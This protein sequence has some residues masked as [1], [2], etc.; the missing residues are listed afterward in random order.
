MLKERVK[1]AVIIIL[2]ANCLFLTSQIWFSQKLWPHGYDFFVSSNFLQKE[3]SIAKENIA[4]PRKLVVY[5]GSLWVPYYNTNPAFSPLKDRV[6][7]LLK[8]FLDG[9]ASQKKEITYE[10]WLNSLNS[11]SVY[12][13]YPITLTGEVLS[14]SMGLLPSKNSKIMIKDFIIMP[15]TSSNNVRLLVRTPDNREIYEY[16]LS[17]NQKF[18]QD[19]LVTYAKG[20][21]GYYEF[22]FNTLLSEAES[23]IRLSPLLLFTD[24]PE[25]V[26]KI[27]SVPV[28]SEEKISSLLKNF[29]FTPN[30]MRKYTDE[31]N[32]V[33]YVENYATVKLGNDG[34]FEYRA[35]SEKDAL[36]LSKTD[37]PYDIL[38]GV[39]DFSEKVWKSVSDSP[40]DV[41]LT[42]DIPKEGD[43][44]EFT[45]D[46]YI[47]GNSV[48]VKI[49]DLSHAIEVSVKGGKIVKY[50]HYLRK[51]LVS[52]EK[53][54]PV[55]FVSA[56][57]DIADLFSQTSDR[58][59]ISDMYLSYFDDG[60]KDLI[61]ANWTA[62]SQKG[63]VIVN[64]EEADYELE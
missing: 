16:T 60:K 12:V 30:P 51:Y 45:F 27:T 44:M 4:T 32:Y 11:P 14:Y 37:T 26:P 53:S 41:L 48:A 5:D 23:A 2:I 47:S 17:N 38:C 50:R 10:K 62:V 63:N 42:S 9:H 34:Y 39:I 25:S 3:Y 18:P 13:E 31:N 56:L 58:A 28:I 52:K 6:N 24:T 33:N 15:S 19:D 64:S 59:E 22:A 20:A 57:D 54:M 55:P 35:S 8:S 29:S 43:S 7:S 21:N 49:N 61:E 1:S 46:A 36:P 40:L